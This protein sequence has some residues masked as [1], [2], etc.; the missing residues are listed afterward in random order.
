MNRNQRKGKKKKIPHIHLTL[1]CSYSPGTAS[2]LA[3]WITSGHLIHPQSLSLNSRTNICLVWS[4]VWELSSLFFFLKPNCTALLCLSDRGSGD[5]GLPPRPPAW[6]LGR[7]TQ[8]DE[9][10]HV[11]F[12]LLL[13]FWIERLWN[14]HQWTFRSKYFQKTPCCRPLC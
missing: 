12:P 6:E 2:G 14:P 13:P 8:R 3:V 7:D 10:A 5:T 9:G 1:T 4:K 11:L